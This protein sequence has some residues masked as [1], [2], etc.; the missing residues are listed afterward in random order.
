MQEI[1]EQC[2]D[3]ARHD[4]GADDTP[5][6]TRSWFGNSPG[7]P[8]PSGLIVAAKNIF[9]EHRTTIAAHR[10]SFAWAVLRSGHSR[11]LSSAFDQS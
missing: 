2:E 11:R 1:T 8:D 10:A 3:D 5:G 6:S 4:R 9:A 7:E